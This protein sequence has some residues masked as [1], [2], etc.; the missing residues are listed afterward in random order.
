MTEKFY[1]KLVKVWRENRICDDLIKIQEDFY[2]KTSELINKLRKPEE[3]I[4][5]SDLRA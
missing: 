2:K 5:E 3:N 1:E 4:L